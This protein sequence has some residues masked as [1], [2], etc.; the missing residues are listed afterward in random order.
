MNPLAGIYGSGTKVSDSEWKLATSPLLV[1]QGLAAT[2]DADTLP[3]NVRLKDFALKGQD[4]VNR[5][6]RR[7]CARGKH[8]PP[9]P[10]DPE[11]GRI[12]IIS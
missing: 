12:I 5:G 10:L 11:A 8:T 4:A 2:H 1:S 3:G 9:R 7:R 6:Q